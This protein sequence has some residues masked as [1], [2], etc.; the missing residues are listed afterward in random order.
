MIVRRRCRRVERGGERL[1]DDL[2]GL[3]LVRDE[4]LPITAVS[5]FAFLR[6]TELLTSELM[7]RRRKR[8]P[9]K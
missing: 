7:P 8:A 3:D 2:L 5:S 6:E 1:A 9:A 4:A